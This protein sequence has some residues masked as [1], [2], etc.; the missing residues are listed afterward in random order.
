M[1]T[2]ESVEFLVT[3]LSFAGIVFIIAIGVV[4]LSQQFRKNLVQQKLEQEKLKNQHHHELLKSS[5]EAQE[6]ERKR[7]A[8][9]LHDELGAVLSISRMHLLKMEEQCEVVNGLPLANVRTLTENAIASMRRISHELMPPLLESFGLA[10][11]LESLSTNLNSNTGIQINFVADELPPLTWPVQIG[12]YRICME[13]IN[14]TIKHAQA[15][16][17]DIEISISNAHLVLHYRDNGKGVG[18]GHHVGGLGSHSIQARVS[19]LSG[20]IVSESLPG[21]GFE[22]K[23]VIEV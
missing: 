7:I 3:L 6:L 21:K 1:E 16:K 10:K 5:I 23:L 18:E 14:N 11:T 8:R 19:A 9:D 22:F 13:L 4:L 15:T 12:L 17:I 2:P 20:R